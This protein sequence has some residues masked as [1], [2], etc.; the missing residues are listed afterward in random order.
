[1]Q[2]KTSSFSL[3]IFLI[4]LAIASRFLPHWH[5]FTAVG[6]VG[7]FGAAFFQNRIWSYAAPLC[8]LFISDLILNNVIYAQYFD[9]FTLLSL[10]ALWTYAAFAGLVFCGAKFLRRLNTKNF[11][12]G[13]LCGTAVFFVVSNFGVFVSTT[14]YPKSGAGLAAAYTAGLPFAL[15]SLL[16]NVCYTAILIIGFQYARMWAS[17]TTHVRA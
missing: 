9:G 7:L 4:V 15:N 13:T 5:N 16:A 11:L 8:A 17:L 6:A 2:R 3:L 1:M 10:D 14:L 12:L